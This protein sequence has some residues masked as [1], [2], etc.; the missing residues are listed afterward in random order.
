VIVSA[1]KPT[2]AVRRSQVLVGEG[3]TAELVCQVDGIP[4]PRISW[5]RDGV[6]VGVCLSVCLSLLSFANVRFIHHPR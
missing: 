5:H 3:E 6:L 1:E 2:V 4:H